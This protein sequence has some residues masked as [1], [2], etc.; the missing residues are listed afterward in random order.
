MW[1]RKQLKD[2]GKASFKANYWKSVLVALVLTVAMF[3]SVTW[4]YSPAPSAPV[5]PTDATQIGDTD[6][7]LELDGD[8]VTLRDEDGTLSITAPDGSGS[9][10]QVT[11]SYGENGEN[12]GKLSLNVEDADED[13]PV[14]ISLDTGSYPWLVAPVM[15]AGLFV[16]IL[17]AL[18]LG[19]VLYAF[20][21]NPLQAGCR[22]FFTANL[23]RPAQVR[24]VACTFDHG[25]V[26]CVK[27]MILRDVFTT[28][29]MLL[30]IIPGIIKSYEY[31]MIPY[32]VADNPEMTWKEAFAESKRLMRGNK[33]KAFVLDL[34]FI[35][36]WILSALTLGLLAVFYVGPYYSATSAALYEELL[37]GS[38]VPP[39][40]SEPVPASPLP[41]APMPEPDPWRGAHASQQ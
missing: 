31:R 1:T 16:T 6:S 20:V 15:F 39:F 38:Q 14:N 34:S 35:G 10:D 3:G 19:L 40:A 36:W 21:Y 12:G 29:W 24:E 11:I 27:A 30:L 32:L 22:G 28:L 7:S 23:N 13:D 2:K 8:G 18:A 25:Y 5:G 26:N 37:Y 33:W 41:A 17:I 4:N 9:N